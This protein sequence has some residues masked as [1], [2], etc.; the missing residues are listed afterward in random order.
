[1]V[2]LVE[3]LLDC[4]ADS[5]LVLERQILEGELLAGAS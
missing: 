5:R 4:E 2:D 3:A 1:L